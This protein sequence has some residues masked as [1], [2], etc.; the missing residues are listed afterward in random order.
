M[1]SVLCRVEV[2]VCPG[3]EVDGCH[4]SLSQS[5]QMER[6]D[7][8]Q[9]GIGTAIQFGGESLLGGQIGVEQGVIEWKPIPQSAGRRVE[10]RRCP[11]SLLPCFG[12]DFRG[13]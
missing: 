12:R 11:V 1:H 2:F 4:L 9:C 13:S 6:D 8:V 10:R 3:T 7:A 5:I